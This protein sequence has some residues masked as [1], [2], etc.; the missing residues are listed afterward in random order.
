MAELE[1][2]YAMRR[3]DGETMG[4]EWLWLKVDGPDDWAPAGDE[5]A[6]SDSS[7]EFEIVKMTVEQV[8]VMTI[9]APR[10]DT[11]G[12]REASHNILTGKCMGDDYAKDCTCAQDKAAAAKQAGLA[13]RLIGQQV[14]D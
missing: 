8:G 1:T 14:H 10:C 9:A 6:Y 13:D 3:T 5:V 7:I 2:F 11:C 4:D 12:H